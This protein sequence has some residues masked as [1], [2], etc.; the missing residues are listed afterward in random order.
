MRLGKLL[1]VGHSIGEAREIMA[2]E[3]LESVEI[4]RAMGHALPRL[5]ARGIIAPE[6]L[7]LLRAL[8]DVILHARRV[9]LSF[10]AVLDQTCG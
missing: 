2:G 1:G 5:T 7:P 3:T 6:D 9:D 10:A 4:L 8:S